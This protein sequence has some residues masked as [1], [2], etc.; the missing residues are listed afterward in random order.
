MSR[1][2]HLWTLGGLA[3]G[4][5]VVAALL[6]WQH[7]GIG[8]LRRE[9]AAARASGAEV[10][11]RR[12][13]VARLAALQPPA[14]EL[15][16]LRADHEAL[17]SL[18]AEIEALKASAQKAATRAGPEA[19]SLE[20]SPA[21]GDRFTAGRRV[22]ADEWTNAGHATPAAAFETL[23]WAAAGGDLETLARSLTV[24]P[25]WRTQIDAW[26]TQVAEATRAQYVTPERLFA[27]LTAKDV[28]LGY[29]QVV[30]HAVLKPGEWGTPPEA[31]H[32]IVS[33]WV[34]EAEANG[35]VITFILR[36]VD[37]GWRVVLPGEAF[38]KY[39]D[40]LK[41]DGPAVGTK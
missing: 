41:G 38:R 35:K 1:R 27:A 2:I 30:H 33:A 21:P 31:E 5:G 19:K 37:D 34:N 12:A 20:K 13:E 26:W 28:P 6:L 4:G 14:T 25:R 29:T 18:R 16:R 24:D 32:A 40:A 17:L 39:R 11:Q 10:Q 22:T 7:H 9:F 8:E 3:T 23:L 36:R 15:E